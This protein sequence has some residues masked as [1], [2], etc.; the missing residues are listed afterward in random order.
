HHEG[1]AVFLHAVLG[2]RAGIREE[3]GHRH[4]ESVR[5]RLQP[6]GADAVRA[7]LVFLD[8]LKRDAELFT[9]FFLAQSEHFPAHPYPA[10]DIN[11]GRIWSLDCFLWTVDHSALT[12]PLSSFGAPAPGPSADGTR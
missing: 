11:V 3:I 12:N 7:F 2:A 6:A 5:H 8:L 4:F 10:A 9:Q 1:G